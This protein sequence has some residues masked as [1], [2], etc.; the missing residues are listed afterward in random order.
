MLASGSRP[1][2][3][4]VALL[5]AHP[6]LLL[7][8]Y[9]SL[10]FRTFHTIPSSVPMHAVFGFLNMLARLITD[11]RPERLAV[12]VDEEWRPAF[13][14]AAIP[15]YKLHRVSEEANPIEPQEALGREVL[16]A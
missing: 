14:V 7:I 12:A 15:S 9:E 2:M 6:V 5:G 8:D 16:G 1:K 10:L 11:R 13:R 3:S 4:W